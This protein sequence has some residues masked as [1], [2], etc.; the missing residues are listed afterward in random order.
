MAL[1]SATE[2]QTKKKHELLG[3][4]HAHLLPPSPLMRPRVGQNIRAGGSVPGGSSRA[5]LSAFRSHRKSQQPPGEKPN[6]SV[7]P[8]NWKPCAGLSSPLC[9]REGILRFLGV[10]LAKQMSWEFLEGKV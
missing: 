6:G 7:R 3:S 2:D 9:G 5:R 8:R 4:L 10:L 1:C